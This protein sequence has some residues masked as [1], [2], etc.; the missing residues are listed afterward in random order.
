[1]TWAA[2]VAVGVTVIVGA[3]V[4][5]GVAVGAAGA[6]AGL[7]VGVGVGVVG[8]AGARVGVGVGV[9]A[10]PPIVSESGVEFV[11]TFS[12][13]WS[14]LATDNTSDPVKAIEVAVA[15]V[16]AS[17]LKVIV[18][19]FAVEVITFA[20]SAPTE[21]VTDAFPELYVGPSKVAGN[22]SVFVLSL[23]P[24]TSSFCES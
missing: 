3:T 2:G 7:V 19:S 24:T 9:G 5:D 10:A 1:M 4:A 12:L 13:G 11:K 16:G 8:A 15:F 17:A 20:G 21:V 14:E 23:S 22:A 18:A 6:P